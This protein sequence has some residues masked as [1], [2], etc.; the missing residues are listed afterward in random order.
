MKKYK[1]I[2]LK[3]SGEA[4]SG[5]IGFG[6]DKNM[7]ENISSQIKS[8]HDMNIEIGIVI[9]GGNFFRGRSSENMSRVDADHIGM[10]ATCMNSLHLKNALINQG[11][12]AVVLSSIKMEAVCEFFSKDKA[13]NYLKQ[14]KIVIFAGGTGNPFFSTDTAASLRAA[15]IS[16]DCILAAKNVDGVYDSD[17]NVNPNAKKY[18]T[19]SYSEI[20]SKNLNV[21][22]MS[23]AS[24]SMNSNTPTIVFSL[25]NPENIISV[26]NGE[27]IGTYI[28]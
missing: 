13:I 8:I 1:R 7:L 16:A 24:L 26:L 10:L 11:I 22:D 2:L 27:N 12:D 3:L 9:G 4:I 5:K 6:V 17:P 21:I 23:A 14:N 20:L 28:S 15:E 19:L 25:K 18:E